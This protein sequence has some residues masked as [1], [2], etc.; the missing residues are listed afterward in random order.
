[1]NIFYLDEDLTLCAQYHCD[2]HVVKMILE[3][4]QILCTVLHENGVSAPYKATHQ[5]HPCV[6]WASASLENWLWLKGLTVELN[7]EYR[8]R[9]H[10]GRSHQS[11][12]VA[13]ALVLPPLPSLGITDRPLVMPDEYKI[14]GQPIASYRRFYAY[15]K[16]HLLKYTKRSPPFWLQDIEK[17]DKR[18]NG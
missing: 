18:K 1:M 17:E 16:K 15:G 7:K 3:S 9:F 13:E 14:I 6:I 5:K 8:Y 2:S 11:S 10:K 12:I 4:V